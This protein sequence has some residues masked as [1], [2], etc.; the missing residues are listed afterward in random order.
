MWHRGTIATRSAAVSASMVLLAFSLASGCLLIAM[1]Y[2]LLGSVDE[3]A[4][5]RVGEIVTALQSDEPG[6]LDGPLLST[7]SQVVAVQLIRGDGTVVAHSI[8]TSMQPLVPPAEFGPQRTRGIN[9]PGADDVRISGQTVSTPAGHYTVLVG[10]G[11]EAVEATLKSVA[12]L[13]AVAA[14]VIAAAAALASYWLVTRSLGSVDAIRNRV[15]EISAGGLAGRVPVPMRRN[16]ISALAETMNEM[17][18][19]LEDSHRSQRQ[20]VSDASH[21]LRSPLATIIAALEVADA[22]PQLLDRNL[23]THTLLPEAQRMQALVEDLLLLARADEHGITVAQED[24]TLCDLLAREAARLRRDTALT[25]ASDLSEVSVQGDP[26]ALVRLVR[27]L[28]DN[29]TRHARSRVEL[30]LR[31]DHQHALVVIGDDG[32]G[33]PAAERGRVFDRF[34]RLDPDRSRLGGGCGLGLAIV[35][36]IVDAHDGTITVGDRPRGG[37]AIAVTLPLLSAGVG[38]A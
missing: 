9:A 26:A 25:V 38:R 19:R 17:L 15:A 28:V 36:E 8:G 4:A 33:I 30:S 29:A 6:E 31:Q 18:A 32:P 7:N 35:A 5:A 22:H 21:E 24:V 11:S 37:T 16:E 13:L 20:F 2:S 23:A 3:A 12:L 1:F 14:P 27:N 10:G 34:V